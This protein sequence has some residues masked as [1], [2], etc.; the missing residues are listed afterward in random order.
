MKIVGTIEARMGSSRLPGKVLK[1]IGGVPALELLVRRVRK[2]RYLD[3][4]VVATTT[5]QRDQAIA[6]VCAR[7]GVGCHRGSED[8]VLDRVLGAAREA[9]ADIICELMGDSPFLDPQLIDNAITAHLAGHYD[10]TSN[11][12]PENTFPMG[13]AVQVFPTKVLARVAE[14]TDDPVDRVHVSCYIYHHPD[15]FRLQGVSAGAQLAAPHLRLCLDTAEDYEVLCRVREGLGGDHE[16]FRAV[17]A[18]DFLRRNP[19]IAL[20]NS[21]VRQKA[22]EEG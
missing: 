15:I 2:A 6:D 11:F 3:E 21:G 13:F 14:L 12:F 18:V 1:P 22:I 7:L 9:G 10:Y 8:D 19:E 20:I 16:D 4:V 5:E 17:E